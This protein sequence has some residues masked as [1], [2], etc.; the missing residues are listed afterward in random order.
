VIRAPLAN[1][2]AAASNGLGGVHLAPATAPITSAL[3][4]T[5]PKMKAL[6]AR[7]TSSTPRACWS[8]SQTADR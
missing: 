7:P 5:I 4:A 3:V 6:S 2:R 1:A 8:P